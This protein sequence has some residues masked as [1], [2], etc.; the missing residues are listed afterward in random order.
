MILMVIKRF[1]GGGGGRPDHEDGGI[2]VVNVVKQCGNDLRRMIMKSE[3]IC[4]AE[5]C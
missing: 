5:K 2:D 3:D 4:E 1:V